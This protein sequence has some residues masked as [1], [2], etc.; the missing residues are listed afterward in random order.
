MLSGH[1]TLRGRN[2]SDTDT[3]IDTRDFFALNIYP[4]PGFTYSFQFRKDWL[5][6][7][8]I[9]KVNLDCPVWFTSKYLIVVNE[10]LF[11]KDSGNGKLHPRC[12]D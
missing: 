8:A 9:L 2:N 12:R 10:P 7:V 11:F 3:P 1:D 6:F 5:I 4:Q